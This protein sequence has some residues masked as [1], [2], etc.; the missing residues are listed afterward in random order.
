MRGARV[1]VFRHGLIIL[2]DISSRV[3]DWNIDFGRQLQVLLFIV[4]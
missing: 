1:V 2:V 4:S 3:R